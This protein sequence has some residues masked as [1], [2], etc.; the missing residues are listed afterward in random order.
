MAEPTPPDD[1]VK[2]KSKLKL[3]ILPLAL[4]ALVGGGTLTATQYPTL[5][6]V[7]H[8]VGGSGDEAETD[9]DAPPGDAPVEY[10]VFAQIDGITVNPVSVGG[11]R[12]LLT[13]I[14][15]EA[16]KEATLEEV[17]E[18]DIVVRD[19]I[20]KLLSAR[21]IE[22]L[23]SV[24]GRNAL[25]DDV[26]GAINSTLRTGQVDRVYFTQYVIQ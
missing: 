18:R 16:A 6:G 4:A 5:A 15:I 10:G 14:G 1:A 17:K 23:S 19:T 22:T 12:Y 8:R 7:V 13:N 21:T 9:D 2:P 20:I 26:R 25:K 11:T 3:L 24:E